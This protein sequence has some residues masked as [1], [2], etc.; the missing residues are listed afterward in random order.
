MVRSWVVIVLSMLLAS[1]SAAQV[2]VTHNPSTSD[3][4]ALVVAQQSM[5]ALTGGLPVVDVTLLGNAT[6]LAGSDVETGPATL[7]ARGMAESR[8]ELNLT[9]GKRTEVRSWADGYPQGAWTKD[10]GSAKPQALHNCFTDAGWFFPALSSLAESSNAGFVTS[11]IGQ[12]TRDGLTVEHVRV[13]R[14]SQGDS[15]I[16]RLSTMDFY[17]DVGTHLP[18]VIVF[19]EHPDDDMNTNIRVEIRFAKYQPVNGVQVPF[20]I[21]RLI[22]GSLNLDLAISSAAINSGVADTQFNLQ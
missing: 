2:S 18:L 20:R 15:N 8:I 5:A 7:V 21:Q 11:Y 22:N 1:T 17:L 12:E 6:W 16:Q 14:V 3:P 10:S 9:G 4:L 13:Y 19:L